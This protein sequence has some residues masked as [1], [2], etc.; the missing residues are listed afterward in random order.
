M[1]MSLCERILFETQ[2]V[3]TE[4]IVPARGCGCN[5]RTVKNCTSVT[6]RRFPVRDAQRDQLAIDLG[7]QFITEIPADEKVG[8]FLVDPQKCFTVNTEPLYVPGSETDMEVLSRFFKNYTP[9]IRKFF[10]SMDSHRTYYP[11]EPK[12]WRS[13][14]DPNV[15]PGVFTQLDPDDILPPNP[16]W[17]A[18]NPNHQT[19]AEAYATCLKAQN[20]VV[21]I[22]PTHCVWGTDSWAQDEAVQKIMINYASYWMTRVGPT[23]A[24]NAMILLKAM[25]PFTEAF[26]A[27]QAVCPN[28]DPSTQEQKLFVAEVKKMDHLILAGEALNFCVAAGLELI[29]F[30]VDPTKIIIAYDASSPIPV[31]DQRTRMVLQDAQ[32]LGVRFANICDSLVL[33]GDPPPLIEGMPLLNYTLPPP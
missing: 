6:S 8:F 7:L 24:P 15:H 23:G 12:F 13:V 32:N 30:G 31:F 28:A 29:D 5:T 17:E 9:F 25:S 4:T 19:Q 18:N 16:I 10:I 11:G 20:E 2:E 1:T 27:V 22:W 3:C 33:Q 26:G 21:F 14:A